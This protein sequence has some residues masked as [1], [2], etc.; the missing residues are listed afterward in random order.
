MSCFHRLWLP[1][2]AIGLHLLHKLYETSGWASGY[3]TFRQEAS[4]YRCKYF[5]Q[6]L[7]SDWCSLA[8][9]SHVIRAVW[10]HATIEEIEAEKSVI[11]E[12]A[13]SNC[14]LYW[15]RLFLSSKFCSST[16]N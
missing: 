7:P 5:K 1:P 10:T 11:E 8:C 13:V 15:K 9:D 6:Y 14:L 3:S 16:F 4:G 2:K 12:Q